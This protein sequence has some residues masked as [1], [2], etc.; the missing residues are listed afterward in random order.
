MCVQV[1]YAVKAAAL[2]GASSGSRGKG[3]K[4]KSA[5]ADSA[6]DAAEGDFPCFRQILMYQ[7]H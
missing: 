1:S 5:G 7:T 4:R 3:R 6:N 2:N